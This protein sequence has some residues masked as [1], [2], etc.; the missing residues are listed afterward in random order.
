M[1][2]Q[3]LVA[4]DGSENS[5][6]AADYAINLARLFNATIRGLFVKDV[7]ILTGPLIHDIGTSIGGMVPYG[8]FNQTIRE[9][10]ESQADAAL[11]QVEGKCAQAKVTFTREIREGIVSREIIK[12][13]DDCDLIAMGK[14]GAHAE[15]R[16]VFLGTNVEYVVRQTH[17]PVLITPSEYKPFRKMLIAYDGSSFADKALRSGTEIAQ[18]MK[19]P[20]T[21]VCVA[22]KKDEALQ[23]LSKAKTF[24]EGY[25]LAVDAVAKEE[26]DHA[27]G[28]LEVCN[29]EDS[30]FDILVMGAYGHSRLQEMILGST[31]VRVMR[32]TN[33]SILLCR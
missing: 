8:T 13:A 21:V 14:M 27:V 1:I 18:A 26:S 2:K 32:S 5:L 25:K 19:L 22:D 23:T 33:C 7:K 17:K 15:W 24:L 28:I 30:K 11:N 16:D 20:I 31:T 4:T 12:S 29:D 6:T 3:I 10:L 9:L